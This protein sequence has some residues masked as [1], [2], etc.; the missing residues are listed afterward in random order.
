MPDKGT[1]KE[2]REWRRLVKMFDDKIDQT[3]DEINT[4]M[5]NKTA[6]YKHCS[7]NEGI[8]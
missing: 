8:I 7:K 4:F 5:E 3:L 2:R 1:R 6:H